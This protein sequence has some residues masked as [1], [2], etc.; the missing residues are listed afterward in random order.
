[1]TKNATTTNRYRI[2]ADQ[3]QNLEIDRNGRIAPRQHD[4]EPIEN[5]LLSVLYPGIKVASVNVPTEPLDDFEESQVENAMARL[6]WNGVH[7]KLVG[8]SGSAKKGKFYFVDQEHSRA[9]AERF[10]HCRRRRSSTS[11]F[12]FHPAK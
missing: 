10:Q 12:S 6:I 11:G 5:T 2:A 7:Y 8:A 9:I 1:M 4:L 3:V